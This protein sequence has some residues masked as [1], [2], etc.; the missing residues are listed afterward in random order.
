MAH[1]LF[2]GDTLVLSD[3]SKG[4]VP[5]IGGGIFYE[6]TVR[7]PTT[8]AAPKTAVFTWEGGGFV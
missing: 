6:V 5:A 3:Q 1:P 7:N 4:S 8:S 2:V